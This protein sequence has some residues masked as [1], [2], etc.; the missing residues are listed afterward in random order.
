MNNKLIDNKFFFD[1]IE[2]CD[3][4]FKQGGL[5]CSGIFK[6]DKKDEPLITI[7]TTVKNGEKFF[8]EALLIVK[9]VSFYRSMVISC[10]LFSEFF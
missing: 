9:Q 3:S 7:I 1:L 5:R 10:C 2:K 4:Q 6:Q 8:Q